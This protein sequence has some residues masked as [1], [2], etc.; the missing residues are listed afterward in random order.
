MHNTDI[1]LILKLS[2]RAGC[3][4]RPPES[5]ITPGG[6]ATAILLLFLI[7]NPM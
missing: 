7:R 2:V 4:I 6:I 5:N 1:N 3:S